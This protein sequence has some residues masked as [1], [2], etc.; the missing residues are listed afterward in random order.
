VEA[1]PATGTGRYLTI[2]GTLVVLTAA[3]VT[4][5][6]LRLAHWS[7]LVSILI[8]TVKG[9]LVLLYFMHMRDESALFRWALLLALTTLGIIMALTF[10]D[11]AF[12]PR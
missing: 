10:S 1:K 2:W 5:A 9:S 12:R 7:A 8:A 11:V 6:G 4:A 3:T